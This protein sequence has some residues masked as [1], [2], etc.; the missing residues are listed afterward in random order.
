[1]VRKPSG[2][3]QETTPPIK[4]RLIYCQAHGLTFTNYHGEQEKRAGTASEKLESIQ[5]CV[6]EGKA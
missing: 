1:M 2:R 3:M 5:Q 6:A 4:R